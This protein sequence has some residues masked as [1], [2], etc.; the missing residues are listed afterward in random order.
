MRTDREIAFDWTAE[1]PVADVSAEGFSVVWQGSFS[2]ERAEY[3]FQ[4]VF[5]GV[6][7]LYIDGELAWSSNDPLQAGSRVFVRRMQA[8]THLIRVVYASPAEG[9][10]ARLFWTPLGGR[11]QASQ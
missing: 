1:L 8:G 4:P 3:S 6:A 9:A 7:S 11:R 2:F 10:A 5:S